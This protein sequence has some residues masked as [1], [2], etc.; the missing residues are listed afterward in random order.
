M[1]C[2]VGGSEGRTGLC[3]GE[4]RRPPSP[5]PSPCRRRAGRQ[6]ADGTHPRGRHAQGPRSADAPRRPVR[7]GL[8]LGTR[9]DCTQAL[10]L[11]ADL[12]AEDR[13]ADRGDDRDPVG[14]AAIAGAPAPRTQRDTRGGIGG[15]T[16]AGPSRHGGAWSPVG[17]ARR[18][19][20]GARPA[21]GWG[22]GTSI[23]WT[24][25]PR[26]SP[27]AEMQYVDCRARDGYPGCDSAS[28]KI[29]R[30]TANG[31]VRLFDPPAGIT[32]TNGVC[33]LYRLRR[34]RVGSGRATESL[35]RWNPDPFDLTPK[36]TSEPCGRN[37]CSR[38]S[39][40]ELV[41]R[42]RHAFSRTGSRGEGPEASS[43]T[44]NWGGNAVGPSPA[45]GTVF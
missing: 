17:P 15:R 44:G 41:P 35:G 20:A 3:G 6:L 26:E 11:R 37:G 8:T 34:R 23:R 43:R 1:G 9:A 38:V 14:A 40:A 22:A 25:P 29:S 27:V 13:V 21:P 2:P 39:H 42:Y 4:D 19:V 33:S 16:P 24:T 12:E 30:E 32:Y 31:S 28:G 5:G 36:I 10:D 7:L 45:T 18:G